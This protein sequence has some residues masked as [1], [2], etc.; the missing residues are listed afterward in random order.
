MERLL[1]IT[2]ALADGSR[3]RVVM[4][5]ANHDELCVCQI[6][7]LLNLAM[8]TV[9][10]HMSVLQNAGLVKSRKDSRWVYYRLAETFPSQCMAWLQTELADAIEIEQDRK[11]LE[12]ILSYDLDE[13]CKMQK[14]RRM[15]N[16]R[17]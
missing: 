7:E 4:M 14:K 1:R 5:L 9:S 17:A 8:P 10:R 6:T 2:K 15:C 16:A 3:L 11:K 13:L 12:N